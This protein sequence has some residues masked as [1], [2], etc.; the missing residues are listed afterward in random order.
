MIWQTGKLYKDVA[1]EGVKG[2]RGI[3]TND[4]I[5]SME[6][7]YAAADI[8]VSR[9]GAMSIAELAVV[10]KPVIFVPYPFAAE[11][12]QTVNASKLVAKGAGL[13]VK[14]SDAKRTLVDTVIELLNNKSKQEDMKR[15]IG[16]TAIS[17]ADEIVAAEVLRII[18]LDGAIA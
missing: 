17:N 5:S 6:N 9:A 4:F 12:H 2:A 11:D 1:I 15:N 16:A 18:D 14:D 13:M 3:Y 8:V 7:A 10:K